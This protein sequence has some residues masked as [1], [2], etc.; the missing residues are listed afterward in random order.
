MKKLY[1]FQADWCMPCHAITPVVKAIS[2]E[3]DLNLRIID[4]D[5]QPDMAEYFSVQSIPTLVL[6]TEDDREIGRQI[7]NAPKSQILANLGLK[8]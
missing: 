8:A 1:K 7:G 3:Y 6:T 2:E 5:E 4:I